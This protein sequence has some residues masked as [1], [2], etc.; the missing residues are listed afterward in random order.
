ME[1]KDIVFNGKEK[2]VFATDNDN[3][4]IIH[5]KDVTLGY[6]NI[7]KAIFRGKGE[8]NC[9]ISAMLFKLLESNGI[10]THFIEAC[11]SD[12]LCRKIDIIPLALTI[13]NKVSGT[14]VS[15]I[16]VDEGTVPEEPLFD[17]HYNNDE[18]ADPLITGQHAVLL[19]LVNKEELAFIYETAGKVNGILS[20]AFH[21][22]GIELVDVKLEF[23]RAA[24]NGEIII[25]DEISPDTCRLWDEATGKILDKTRFLKDLSDVVASYHEVYQ[26]LSQ[27]LSD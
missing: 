8:V 22:A 18:F 11:G 21:K 24:D 10:R 2:K 15:R 23:G 27:V 6:N 9:R 16:G 5:F 14:L 19:G 1:K 26:R 7:K 13:R 4:I 20:E 25:S 17:L 12:M 3:R